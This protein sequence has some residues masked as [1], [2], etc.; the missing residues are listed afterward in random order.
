MN[1]TLLPAIAALLCCAACSGTQDKRAEQTEYETLTI[2]TTDRVLESR[3]TATVQGRQNV[4][5]RPQVSGVITRICI[6]EG[7][8]VHKGQTLFVIDQAPYRSALD[9]ARA[10]VR[11]AGAKLATARISAESKD[12]LYRQQ[13]ISLFELQTAQNALNEA[14]AELE[15]A[16]AQEASA[17]NDLSY[18]EVKSPVDGVA[19]MIPY[20]EGALVSSTIAEPLVTVSDDSEVYAYFSM[21]ENQWLDLMLKAGSAAQVIDRMPQ[22]DFILSNGSAYP[23]KGRIDAISGTIDRSTGSISVR[24][25]FPNP[26]RLLRNGSSGRVVI[27]VQHKNC[28]VIPQAATYE[29]QNK[30]FTYRVVDGKTV[31]AP[32]EVN[33]IDNG[34]EYIVTSGLTPGDVIIARG[35]GLL[36]EGME[37][38]ARPAGK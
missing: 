18:T 32:I 21:T 26:E 20:R 12:A 24:A 17:R 33:E 4:E 36:R 34:K 22:V 7:A 1:K 28:I 15:Q 10:N 13:V 11:S 29:L 30:V 35:A 19:S 14:Q 6:R 2:S 38:T 9:N 23:H 27:P 25:V 8:A 31:S 37:V 3:Y 16:R 5:I